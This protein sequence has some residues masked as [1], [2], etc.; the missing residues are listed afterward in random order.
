MKKY[1]KV[2]Y[3]DSDLVVN[4]D[5]A[6]LYQVEMEDNLIAATLDVDFIGQ[7][8]APDSKMLK[9]NKEILKLKDPYK[10]FQA[11]VLV[12]NIPAM[13]DKI[14]VT[15]LLEIA[16][17]DLYLFSDQDILNVLCQ[18][19]VTYLD[20]RW[21]HIY[22]CN[23]ERIKNVV[24]WD[25]VFLYEKYME[26]R[27]APYIVHYAGFSKPWDEPEGEFGELFWNYAKQTPYYEIMLYRMARHVADV[28]IYYDKMK[29]ISLRSRIIYF[30]LPEG[31]TR[32]DTARKIWCKVFGKR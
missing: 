23:G 6:K 19:R 24:T 25:P 20:L 29:H 1:K 30:F 2:I 13:R 15:E 7:L 10:Y 21:N 22:D 26:A 9:Y 3:I 16:D 12:F 31:S 14:T 11:G 18:G 4:E 8:N 32:R 28:E 27:K 5:I 17:R